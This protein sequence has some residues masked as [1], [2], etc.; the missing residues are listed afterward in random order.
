MEVLQPPYIL[1]QLPQ[2]YLSQYCEDP[3]RINF[4][5]LDKEIRSWDSPA[6]PTHKHLPQLLHCPQ[7]QLQQC[8]AQPDMH[9]YWKPHLNCQDILWFKREAYTVGFNVSQ[10]IV[11]KELAINQFYH[12]EVSFSSP[13]LLLPLCCNLPDRPPER[14]SWW[15]VTLSSPHLTTTSHLLLSREPLEP[16]HLIRA[17]F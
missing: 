1:V 5:E 14:L 13:F 2:N 8:P 4:R 16:V 17:N 10:E 3:A 12:Q 6:S 9:P 15:V 7:G 11:Q